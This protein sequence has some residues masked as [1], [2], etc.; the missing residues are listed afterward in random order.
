V[1]VDPLGVDR[2]LSQA[3]EQ[4]IQ[5]DR[6]ASVAAGR[7]HLDDLSDQGQV[8]IILG[9]AVMPRSGFDPSFRFSYW[10]D[11]DTPIVSLSAFIGYR[12]S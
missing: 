12:P 4:A 9:S 5:E 10:R 3:A 7:A 1:P 8:A 6:H 2:R 11:L